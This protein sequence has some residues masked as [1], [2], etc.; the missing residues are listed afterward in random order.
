MILAVAVL[1]ILGLAVAIAYPLWVGAGEMSADD[2]GDTREL[3]KREKDVALLAIREA[4]LD[5][6]MGKLSDEDYATLRQQYERRAVAALGA[7]DR[8][9]ES[10]AGPVIA[11]EGPDGSPARARFCSACGR[12]HRSGERFCAGCGRV[13]A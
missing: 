7:L 9:D 6:A 1:M 13:R 4:E 11:A 10:A 8:I 3:L 5:R 2:T 12:R